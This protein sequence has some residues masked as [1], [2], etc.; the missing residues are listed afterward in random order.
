MLGMP[1][2]KIQVE[3]ELDSYKKKKRGRSHLPKK[4]ENR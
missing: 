2:T 4:E 1:F 3:K